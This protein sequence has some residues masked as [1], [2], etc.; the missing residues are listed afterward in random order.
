MAYIT[1]A[2]WRETVSRRP[3]PPSIGAPQKAVAVLCA[4]VRI[5]VDAHLVDLALSEME[6]VAEATCGRLAA[7]PGQSVVRCAAARSFDHDVITVGDAQQG[8][9]VVRQL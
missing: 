7:G 5:D 9:V 4:V 6:N 2:Q 1:A 3:S 8:I